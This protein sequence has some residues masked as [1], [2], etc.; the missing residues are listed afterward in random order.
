M[1]TI[2]I[3]CRLLP[4]GAANVLT[5]LIRE[6]G[7]DHDTKI[8]TLF[9]NSKTRDVNGVSI[10]V[11][12]AL[13]FRIQ[14]VF[15]FF[16]TYRVPL[17]SR[18]FD[19]RNLILFYPWLIARL[20]RKIQK[21]NPDQVI[22]SS[23][24]VAKNIVPTIGKWQIVT[25]L[26]L[27]SPMQYIHTHRDEYR[28][29]ITGIKW[30]IFRTI[31]YKLKKRDTLPRIYDTIITNSNYTATQ[32]KDIYGMSVDRVWYPQIHTAFGQQAPI[33]CP[34]NYFV[35]V[36]RLVK[37]VKK[38]DRLIELV[39]ATGDHLVLIG[40]GP[41]EQYLKKIAGPNCLFI[42]RVDDVDKRIDIIR[43]S[44]WLLNI[45]KESFGLSTAEA[46]LC[47]V[48]VFWYAEGASPELIDH[49]SGILTCNKSIGGLYEDFQAF[50]KQSWSREYIWKQAQWLFHL[51]T[52]TTL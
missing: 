8:F 46:L 47:G 51:N 10:T 13:P 26:Y 41:D 18:L 21:H 40:S 27:H 3:H 35:Y 33:T 17:L 11:V 28:Q 30:W 25:I 52:K 4:W 2:Y 14:S 12:G 45:T 42:G 32:A 7:H 19:Y 6:Y 48:P 36:G 44:R 43:K 50:K 9:S 39:N 29:K 16:Q 24:A 31:A 1:S 5:D 37:F 34:D 23:F 38:V 22:I 20:R 15:L 49:K